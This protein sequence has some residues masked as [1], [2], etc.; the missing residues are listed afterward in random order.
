MKL[1]AILRIKNGLPFV[2]PCLSKLE[3]L[4]DEII[5]LDNGSTDGTLENYK[6]FKKIVEIIY[7]KD[8]D[9]GRDKNLLLTAA[10]KRKPDWILMIDSDEIFEKNLNRLTIE[11]YMRS[12]YNRVYF[13]L[14]H[15]CDQQY[16]RIDRPI[17]Y[18]TLLPLRSMWRNINNRGFFSDLKIHTGNVHGINEP[19]HI[20]PYRIKHYGYI[21]PA[22]NKNKLDL[23]LSIKDSR[24][25]QCKIKTIL[26]P[27]KT[28]S[29]KFR[30]FENDKVNL[31]Y[32]LTYKYIT[33]L[34]F[35]LYIQLVK[36]FKGVTLKKVDY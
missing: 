15:F 14:C 27:K 22:K 13:R 10:K 34:I 29:L 35:S 21:D 12:R 4:V 32:I 23:Y 36:I 16:F 30:E 17:L 18:L 28:L 5:V 8:F 1:V 25:S 6:D 26:A 7:T 33:G 31:I 11:K 9:E 3:E 20:S 2:K 19:Y 24:V